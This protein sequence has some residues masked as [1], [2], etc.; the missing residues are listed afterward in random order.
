GKAI[1]EGGNAA[2]YGAIGGAAI[3]GSLAL[4][5][6]AMTFEGY[7]QKQ[8][9]LA[10]QKTQTLEALDL[11]RDMRDNHLAHV[12]PGEPDV[13]MDIINDARQ[14]RE[15]ASLDNQLSSV[16]WERLINL[17]GSVSGLAMV[18]SN[19]VSSAVRLLEIAQK[20]REVL[21]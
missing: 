3:A 20:E 18:I 2:L 7:R 19:T 6:T 21:Q 9:G 12:A 11:E 14:R 4:A 5:G 10:T 13:V 1:R 16:K 15:S 8:A 17:G